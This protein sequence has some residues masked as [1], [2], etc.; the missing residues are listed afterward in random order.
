MKL[1]IDIPEEQYNDIVKHLT[2]NDGNYAYSD[3]NL[4]EIIRNGTP[5]PKGH[6][7]LIEEPTETDISNTV[8]GNNDFA[9]CIRDSVKAVFDNATT[10]VEADE[11]NDNT[12]MVCG[13]DPRWCERCVSK[14]KCSSTRPQGDLISRE[15]VKANM[16]KAD[17][18]SD[19]F[20]MLVELY[21]QIIDN[22]QAIPLP[23]EQIAWEQGYEAGLAQGKHD[24][25]GEWKVREYIE[26]DGSFRGYDV[27][28]SECGKVL[29]RLT[30]RSLSAE[31]A[32]K[33]MEEDHTDFCSKCGADMRKGSAE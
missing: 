5:L 18:Q 4:R 30:N 17:E 27:Y 20:E 31:E 6:G 15:A 2:D 9:E 10:I 12:P 16:K 3:F 8:G 14:G 32:K 25:K 24:K 26:S 29:Y 13:N 23:N 21:E 1:I 19:T 33:Y 7:R 22:A 28:C 11:E